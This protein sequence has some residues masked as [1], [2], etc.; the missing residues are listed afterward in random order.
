L[1]KNYSFLVSNNL[2]F[3]K[4]H[5]ELTIRLMKGL[6]IYRTQGLTSYSSNSFYENLQTLY[7]QDGCSVNHIWNSNKIRI[8]A[9]KQ[10]DAH[11]LAK[12]GSKKFYNTIFKSKEWLI[13]NCVVNA[14]GQ[15]IPHAFLGVRD[16]G[17]T[18]LVC[19]KK[20]LHGIA[21]VNAYDNVPILKTPHFL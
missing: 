16:C 18:T 14:I 8:Q 12:W 4:K 2:I 5:L 17:M 1:F 7:I 13:V 10:L 20:D 9:C 3:K 6:K 21:K 11:V 19:A 15:S